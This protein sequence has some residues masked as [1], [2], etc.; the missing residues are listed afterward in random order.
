MDPQELAYQKELVY[1]ASM[2]FIKIKGLEEFI[3]YLQLVDET[4]RVPSGSALDK[5]TYVAVLRLAINDYRK[6]ML[7]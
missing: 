6:S 5:D 2:E 7:K 4:D 3:E 1:K